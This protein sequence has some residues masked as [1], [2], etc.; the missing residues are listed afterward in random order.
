MCEPWQN[1]KTVIRSA[2][3]RASWISP[4]FWVLNYNL[5]TGIELI[6]G[7]ILRVCI[8]LLWQNRRWTLRATRCI[9]PT[10]NCKTALKKHK[11]AKK[12]KRMIL[13]DLPLTLWKMMR[14]ISQRSSIL[15][16]H[17]VVTRTRHESVHEK[18]N[19]K[20][21]FVLKLVV[22]R[23]LRRVF[24]SAPSILQRR[25]TI[26]KQSAKTKNN[27]QAILEIYRDQHP[28]TSYGEK[29]ERYVGCS[30]FSTLGDCFSSVFRLWRFS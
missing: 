11:N 16:I 6:P 13:W 17:T 27:L 26:S 15:L 28:T 3:D 18:N 4:S 23:G 12:D 9:G 7:I 19:W 24:R 29:V 8:E 20:R 14:G 22:K 30:M 10:T 1:Q 2:I 5:R 25:K 21:G